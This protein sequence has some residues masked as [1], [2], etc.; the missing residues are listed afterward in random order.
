M[1]DSESLPQEDLACHRRHCQQEVREQVNMLNKIQD[2]EIKTLVTWTKPDA[3][4]SCKGSLSFAGDDTQRWKSL[5]KLR[6]KAM[7][8]NV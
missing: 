3:R 4:F 1:S 7:Y 5:G 8:F 2:V 6:L